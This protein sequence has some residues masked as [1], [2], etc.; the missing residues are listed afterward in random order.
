MSDSDLLDMTIV[1]KPGPAQSTPTKI[2][3]RI[4]K[5]EL[6]RLMNESVS[7]Q[8]YVGYYEVV[9]SEGQPRTLFFHW[10]DVLYIG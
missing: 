6:H 8:M 10:A 7:G 1:F 5:T 9:G 3:Y 2:A 4:S